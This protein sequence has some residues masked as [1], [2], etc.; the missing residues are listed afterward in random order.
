MNENL[1]RLLW[2]RT[3]G[4]LSVED[5]KQLEG[6]LADGVVAAEAERELESLSRLLSRA[7][8]EE[9]EVP[10]SLRSRVMDTVHARAAVVG[11]RRQ[12]VVGVAK[13][14]RGALATGLS[15]LGD[16]LWK[17]SFM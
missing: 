6:L 4:E 15:V 13:S 12:E 16:A 2:Q 5:R 10:S 11:R 17:E 8:F 3:D 9:V 1:E 7:R 14:K